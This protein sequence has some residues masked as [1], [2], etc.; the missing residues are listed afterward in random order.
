M[1]QARSEATRMNND[2]A[3]SIDGIS[4]AKPGRIVYPGTAVTRGDVARYYQAVAPRLLPEIAG[5]PLSLLRCPDGVGGEHFFQRH[6]GKGV[7]EHVR[8]VML[9]EKSGEPAPYLCI[10]DLRGLLELVRIGTIELH[11]WGSRADAPERPDRL[12]LDLDPG[13]GVAWPEVI[14][15]A[16]EIRGELRRRGL[17]SFVRLTGGKGLHVAAPFAAGPGWG[18]V[19]DFCEG[20]ARGLAE[21]RPD[22]Y[23]ASAPKRLRPGHIFIDWLR[24]YRS[25]TSI[26]NWSLRARAGAPVAM[27]L[28]WEELA[29]TRGGNHYDLRGALRRDAR[30]RGDPWPEFAS[31]RQRLPD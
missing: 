26:A 22:R 30:L 8:T 24:N 9:E 27:P 15:A 18:Q 21:R 10:D 28:R 13:E 5:R 17:R 14:A 20:I 19:K 16:R 11:V 25:A 3:L 1:A 6:P 23:V 31:L 29:A 7:G 2:A 4:I 12:V